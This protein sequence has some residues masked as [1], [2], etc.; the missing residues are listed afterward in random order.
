MS[1]GEWSDAHVVNAALDIH[2]DDPMFRYRFT[3]D[4]LHRQGIKVSENTMHR[5][6]NYEP[7]SQQRER[8]KPPSSQVRTP[9]PRLGTPLKPPDW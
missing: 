9:F 7:R 8:R 1:D 5:L 4:G 2:R 6:A 3:T